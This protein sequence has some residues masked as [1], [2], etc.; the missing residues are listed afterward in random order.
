[1][2]LRVARIGSI[3][4]AIQYDDAD[5]DSAIEVDTPIRVNAAPANANDV[6]RQADAPG[7]GALG[8]VVGPGSSTDTAF[9]RFNGATGKLIQDGPITCDSPIKSGA[10]QAAAGA[11]AGELWI[12]SGH[13][14]LPD[15]VVM[16]GV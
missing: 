6:L 3:P 2:V 14:S 4:D 13:A 16:L 11:A 12:T 9:A 8:D 10:T 1:M 5:F 7:A 15:N